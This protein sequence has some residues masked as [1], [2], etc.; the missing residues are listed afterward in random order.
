MPPST[1]TG[2][3]GGRAG[4]GEA[5]PG[6]GEGAPD[7]RRRPGTGSVRAFAGP[8]RP[9]RRHRDDPGPQG[10]WHPPR[11]RAG[12]PCRPHLRYLRGEP[13][14]YLRRWQQHQPGGCTAR[15][16]QR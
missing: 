9:V 3:A 5:G 4:A 7:Q 16:A 14:R 13:G 2:L 15:G 10:L 1:A 8:R 12:W 11:A 6:A